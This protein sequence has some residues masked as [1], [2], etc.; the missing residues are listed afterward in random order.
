VERDRDLVVA[1]AAVVI[2]RLVED[3]APELAQ[4]IGLGAVEGLSSAPTT[5]TEMPRTSSP[6]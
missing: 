3:P 2:E 1:R 5:A 4:L 6:A